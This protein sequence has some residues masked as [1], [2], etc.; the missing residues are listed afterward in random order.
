MRR[1]ED[2]T[3]AVTNLSKSAAALPCGEP[4]GRLLALRGS[5][6]PALSLQSAERHGRGN[7]RCRKGQRS[8]AR[9][10]RV[11]HPSPHELL[12]GFDQFHFAVA[13]AVED[14]YF[15]FGV[16]EDEDV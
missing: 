10:G 2:H 9:P 1:L 15:A 7:R 13:G 4:E 11:R 12:W 6:I 16:A 8:F 5:K 14:H 3:L